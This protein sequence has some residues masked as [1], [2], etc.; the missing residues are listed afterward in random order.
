MNYSIYSALSKFTAIS[1]LS[2]RCVDDPNPKLSNDIVMGIISQKMH[3]HPPDRQQLADSSKLDV[4]WGV[5]MSHY[6][7]QIWK[8]IHQRIAQL[9]PFLD[10]QEMVE[11]MDMAGVDA[12]KLILS[13]LSHVLPRI[14]TSSTELCRS[15][16]ES[17]WNLCFDYR[18]TDHFWSVMQHLMPVV[19]QSALMSQSPVIRT[20]IFGF[21]SQLKRMGENIL[22]LFN[23]GVERVINIWMDDNT[24]PI[25][26]ELSVQF[27]V[28]V[29][30]FG[31]IHRRDEL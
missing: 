31:M 6:F 2:I 21:L 27:I 8:L 5:F 18:R 14:A 26:D 13:C 24:F 19:F 7:A 25:V 4:T 12:I 3:C 15:S 1:L 23:I 16:L 28:D 9:A 29:L 10:A 11:A 17:S 30:T 20:Q 22:Q